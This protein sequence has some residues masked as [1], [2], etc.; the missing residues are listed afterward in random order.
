MTEQKKYLLAGSGVASISAA[1]EIRRLDPDGHVTLVGDEPYYYRGSLSEWIAGKTT[2]PMLPGRTEEF[3][4]DMGI[5]QLDGRV[6]TVDP[7]NKTVRLENGKD[8][9]YDSLLIATGAE[10]RKFPVEGLA[11][12]RSYVFRSLD[13]ARKIREE[14]GCC[15]SVLILGG[16]VLGLELAGALSAMGG[17]QIAIVQLLPFVGAPLIDKQSADWLQRRIRAAEVELFLEDTVERVEHNTAI[18]KSGKTWD[19]DLFIQAVGVVPIFPEIPGLEI[20]RGIRIGSRSQTNLDSIYAAGDC[21]ETKPERSDSWV[22]TRT[23]LHSARQGKIAG[24]NMVDHKSD[25]Q[26][27]QPFYNVSI[28]FKQYYSYI[29]EPYGEDGHV[30]HWEDESSLRT[31]RVV[32]G[33]LAGAFFLGDSTVCRRGSMAVLRAIGQDISRF[34]KPITNP[35]FPWNE[36]VTGDWDYHFY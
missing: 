17:K 30:Y 2:D 27:K 31:M 36:L 26:K 19:F 25:F 16:G 7:E 28:L 15:G 11:P 3:Y 14:V 35:S 9:P 8:L 22:P 34:G 20:G 10:A 5:E 12:E 4:N 29:G 18:L 1:Q 23:W 6:S 24:R 32:E 33:C 21:T 13:D